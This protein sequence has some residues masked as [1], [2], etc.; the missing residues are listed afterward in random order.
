MRDLERPERC[1]AGMRRFL[2]IPF[3]SLL[4]LLPAQSGGANGCPLPC[5]GQIASPEDERLLYVQPEGERG[6]VS[7]YDTRTSKLRFRLPKG[8]SSA[9]GRWHFH[10]YRWLA[11]TRIPAFAVSTGR[12]W[13]TFTVPGRWRIGGVSPQGR[14]LVLS[15]RRF[16]PLR[17]EFSILDASSGLIAHRFRLRGN[18][19]V[20]TVSPDG[21]RLFLIEHLRENGAPR[22]LVRLYN[23]GTRRLQSEPLRGGK[24]RVMAGY[25]WSGVAS[26]D[27][28]WL[29]TL[30]LNT[31]RSNAF[32]HAL[33]LKKSIPRCINLPSGRGQFDLLKRYSLTLSP[34]GKT[35]YAA[36][37]AIG[38]VAQIDLET[39]RVVRT[40]RFASQS[41]ERARRAITLSGTI[42]GNGRTLYFSGGRS[43]WAYDTAY[44]R[45][46]GPYPAGATIVGFGY[47]ESDR[48][49]HALLENGRMIA[50]DAA[51]GNRL[52]A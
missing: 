49:V 16:Q 26:P 32:V 19:E 38:V 51:T 44:G 23:I 43:L 29:L 11:G 13:Q 28:R 6:P 45:V 24:D 37:P 35:L 9:D 3:L 2:F 20:E 5:S 34:N 47:G 30:Y 18:F 10:A 14:W 36:N 4:L 52:R 42:S 17:T 46:R 12:V 25:A 41:T 21:R 39:R 48:R 7:V 31:L 50:F 15:N 8:L 22:Y 1:I 33:D 27:G 40:S